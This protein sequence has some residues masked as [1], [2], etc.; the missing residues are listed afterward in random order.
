MK[1]GQKRADFDMEVCTF[2]CFGSAICSLC[3]KLF[4]LENMC[5]T[6]CAL[7]M[8]QTAFLFGF[9]LYIQSDM[10]AL[11]SEYHLHARNLLLTEINRCRMGQK[12]H[13]KRRIKTGLLFSLWPHMHLNIITLASVYHLH[14]RN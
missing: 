14:S 8:S 3:Q 13:I 11:T 1:K 6:N 10:I 2:L 4:L 12:R 5:T 9:W 7:L